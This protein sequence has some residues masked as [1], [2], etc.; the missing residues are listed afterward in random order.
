M[1]SGAG[2]GVGAWTPPWPADGLVVVSGGSATEAP[3]ED[4]SPPD[5]ESVSMILMVE[6]RFDGPAEAR[7][8]AA[9]DTLP[10]FVRPDRIVWCRNFP[11]TVLGKVERRALSSEHDLKEHEH[12]RN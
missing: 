7:L 2:L 8:R 12:G 9:I 1:D 5:D 3:A 11:R 10:S 4:R 6:A